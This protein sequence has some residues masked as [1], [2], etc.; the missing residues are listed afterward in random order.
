MQI[1]YGK[2]YQ[3]KA[4]N[5]LAW[6]FQPEDSQRC[7]NAVEKFLVNP[8]RPGL[9]FERLG[10]G[11]RQN[12]CS[13][14]ASRELRVILAV[15][16]NSTH[17]RR[18][19]LVNMGHHDPMYDW[20]RRQGHYTDLDAYGVVWARPES[21]DDQDT[22]VPPA[23][24][25]EWTL[26][27]P[28][29]QRKLVKRRYHAGLGRVR[30]AAGTGKTVVAL[31]RAA[32]LGHRYPGER[33]LV[34]TFSRSL[35]NHMGALF[36]RFPNAPD[37]V[38]FANVDKL[39]FQF[40]RRPLDLDA[41]DEAFETAY[42]STIPLD[43]RAR[44]DRDYLREEVRLIIK[45]RDPKKEEYLDAGRFERLGR[46]RSFKQPD[47]E[48][49]WRLR[50]AWDREMAQRGTVDFADR[51][52]EA[53]NRAREEG[54]PTYRAAVVDE[55]QDLTLVGI[56]LVRALVAGNLSQKLRT[57]SLLM[58]DDA[59]QRIYPGG[60][61]P[62]WA[63]LNFSGN[64]N[65]LHVNYRNSRRIFRAAQAVRGE[66]IISKDAND[67]GTVD[68]VHFEGAEGDRPVLIVTSGK[69]SAVILERIRH[70]IENKGFKYTEI[71]VLVLRNKDASRLVEALGSRNIP[72]VNL[73]DLRDGP[74]G[75]GV[76]VGTFDRAKGMEFRAVFIP[77]LG[78]SRF[79]IDT[80]DI[81]SGQLPMLVGD[82]KSTSPMEEEDQEAR[83]LNL[84]RLYVA[85][86][87]ARDRLYLIADE[88]PC[89]EIQRVRDY[90][91]D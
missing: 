60:F 3:R 90:H 22:A 12:H 59:A 85:M 11:P 81:G 5:P 74:L 20:A 30:G 44:L 89:D 61:R 25:E 31:H 41:V 71:G 1:L 15:E 27:L 46:R 67:D 26:Y 4:Q 6:R 68:A 88:Q 33:I 86:T 50:E 57:D 7:V 55:A 13:I 76:R 73:V 29:Q 40:D 72:S 65:S 91:F 79:P 2:D 17:P 82:N 52:V 75:D 51:L 69:E 70:L 66:A 48:M 35:C 45:G 37:N 56:Q 34:T 43:I 53:R 78:Q 58:L 28:E 77:R 80:E 83:L 32:V 63:N 36:R 84:D 42:K 19:G 62:V 87:R 10:S 49:C 64:S 54:Q 38:H 24:F 47:R 16:P 18:V 21:A 39:A 23:D 9:N 8:H 14:R